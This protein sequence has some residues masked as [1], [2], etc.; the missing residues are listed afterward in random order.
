VGDT[1]QR[2]ISPIGLPN[3]KRISLARKRRGL[4]QSELA[5][6]IGVHRRAVCAYEVGEYFPSNDTM[7]RL[8][9]A[10]AFPL[11]FF[12]GDDLDEP[13]L[14]SGSFRSMTKMMASHRDMALTQAAIGIHVANWLESQFDLPKPALPDLGRESSPEVAAESLRRAWGIGQLPIRNMVHLLE[15]KGVR[16]FSLA[17]D[18]KEVDAFSMWKGSTPFVFLNTFKS[19][20]HSRFDSAHELGHLVL[21]RNAPQG[22]EAEREADAFA[23]AFLMPRPGVLAH[24]PKFPSLGTLV[25]LKKVWTVSVIALTYRLHFLGLLSDWQY[26]GFCVE[27]TKRGYRESEPEE[28]PRETSLVLPKLFGHLYD[29]GINRTRIAQLLS[30]PPSELEALLFGL[31]LAGIDGGRKEVRIRSTRSNLIRLK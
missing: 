7:E 4:T 11:G 15:A 31:V 23:S 19:S 17:V 22:R 20:E 27:L 18:A 13:T 2:T 16:V 12:Y 29:E 3:P 9:S 21:H 25:K 1:S 8:G 6:L 26:R 24:V 30:I 14:E 10:L 28:A 5:D